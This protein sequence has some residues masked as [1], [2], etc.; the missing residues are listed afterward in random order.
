ML[1]S[2]KDATGNKLSAQMTEDLDHFQKRFAIELYGIFFVCHDVVEV[3]LPPCGA[4]TDESA[5][6]TGVL[7]T[8]DESS[9][10]AR[11]TEIMP[12]PS[13]VP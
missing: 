2:C 1:P 11:Q 8:R 6:E 13:F 5:G 10:V 3:S 4:I 9:L 12:L 7:N